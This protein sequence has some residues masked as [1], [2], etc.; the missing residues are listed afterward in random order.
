MGGNRSAR[1][2]D[3]LPTKE[4]FFDTMA[5][6]GGAAA[7]GGLGGFYGVDIDGDGEYAYIQC[8]IPHDFHTLVDLVIVFL[9]TANNTAMTCRFTVNYC[10]PG[11]AYTQQNKTLDKEYSVV[12]N[13]MQELDITDMVDKPNGRLAARDYLGISMS[14]QGQQGLDGIIIGARLKYNARRSTKQTA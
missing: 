13:I 3:Q 14:R 5:C 2:T 9:P 11:E 1:S 10:R 12:Q 8:L 7:F 6:S 4:V